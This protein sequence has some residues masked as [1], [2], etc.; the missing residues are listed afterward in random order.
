V[1]SAARHP[2]HLLLAFAIIALFAAM[3]MTVTSS[4][5]ADLIGTAPAS[6]CDTSSKVFAPWGDYAN[7]ALVPGGSFESR[8]PAWAMSGGAKVVAGN[9]TFYVRSRTD[10][11]SLYLPSGSSALSPTVCFALGDWH[12]RF[13]VRNVGSSGGSLKVDIVVKSL[14]GGLVSI[15]DG[16]SVSASGTWAPSSRVRLTL[17]NLC[18]LLGVRAVAFRFRTSGSG[19]AYQVDDVYLD[20]WKSF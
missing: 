11:R 12:S 6:G 13:F 10:S 7:Y 8:T 2:R 9:E 5:K 18:S 20:P 17:T 4:A 1:T 19:A 14:V 16:G 15:L 3:A